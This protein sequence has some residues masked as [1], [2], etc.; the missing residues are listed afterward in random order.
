MT[1]GRGVAAGRRVTLRG[2]TKEIGG[3]PV[4]AVEARVDTG[5]EA[6][7]AQYGE[8]ATSLASLILLSEGVSIPAALHLAI[9]QA[10]H[11]LEVGV[12]PQ[13]TPGP[14]H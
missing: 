14:L 11:P 1:R 10:M 4:G 13:G 3:V 8:D 5:L 6:N 12:T 7:A 9:L 2:R